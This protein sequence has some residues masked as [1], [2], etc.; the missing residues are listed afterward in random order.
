MATLTYV[1]QKQFHQQPL[2]AFFDF[3]HVGKKNQYKLTLEGVFVDGLKAHTQTVLNQGQVITITMPE[4]VLDFK[5]KA[6]IDVVYEDEDILIVDKP[7][8]LLVHTDGVANDDLNQRVAY[9]MA[10]Q[11]YKLEVLPAH[12]LDK[13]TS[14][15]V[16]YAKHVL[17]L[18]YLSNLFET[19]QMGKTYI[20]LTSPNVRQKR[21]RID[22][23][24]G[25]SRHED[26]QIIHEQGQSALSTYEVLEDKNA[27]ARLSV[28]ILGGRKHQ[29]RVHLAFIGH[30]I[31]GDSL[32]GG[33]PYDRL[34][35]HFHRVSFVHPRSLEKVTFKSNVPF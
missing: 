32:Y 22:K 6:P 1:V 15:M 4:M 25:S 24:I 29:I 19:H 12:R 9:Y 26:K 7:I 13:D 33:L 5:P 31:L 10:K 23:A 34:A 28:S 2:K 18:S 8:Q 21:G 14:G 35:L 11:G 3:Y 16:I 30:P 20:A 17:A 27:Y